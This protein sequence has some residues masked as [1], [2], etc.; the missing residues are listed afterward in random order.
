[1]LKFKLNGFGQLNDVSEK[2]WGIF[3]RSEKVESWETGM[4]CYY[5]IDPRIKESDVKGATVAYP[6]A[7]N[8]GWLFAHC[9][10]DYMIDHEY[11]LLAGVTTAFEPEFRKMHNELMQATH[12]LI[13]NNT[14]EKQADVIAAQKAYN[15]L[16]LF[17]ED[18][19]ANVLNEAR[20]S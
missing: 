19:R 6:N 8:T 10:S 3:Q 16:G 13:I 17:R 14:L 7:D 9:D 12:G 5:P 2:Y 1:M 4:T 18:V 11:K 15:N 20:K